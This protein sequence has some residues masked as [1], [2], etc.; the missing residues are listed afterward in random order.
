M[1]KEL[2]K[3]SRFRYIDNIVITMNN[4]NTVTGTSLFRPTIWE[5]QLRFKKN[6]S[7]MY[8]SIQS[9]D[10]E[11]FIQKIYSTVETEEKI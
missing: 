6:N 7:V 8:T 11:E 4:P 9:N 1:L 5:A 2:S 10:T 3:L